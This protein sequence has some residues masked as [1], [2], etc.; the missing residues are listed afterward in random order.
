M[1]D[2]HNNDARFAEHWMKAQRAVSAYITAAIPAFHDSEDVLQKVAVVAFT[3]RDAFDPQR[4]SFLTWAIGIARF[5]IQTWR[6]ERS[7]GRLTFDEK[8]LTALAEAHESVVA[9]EVPEIQAALRECLSKV[10]GRA[11]AMLDMRYQQALKS[12]AIAE[13]FKTS[14]NVVNVTLSRARASLAECVSRSVGWKDGPR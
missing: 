6:R 12:A 13:H 10:T 14:E 2:T 1:S 5:E 3:K 7:A 8:T 9:D 4:S 11:R